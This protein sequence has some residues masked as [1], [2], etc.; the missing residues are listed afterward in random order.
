MHFVEKLQGMRF[1]IDV[2]CTKKYGL[3]KQMPM[4]TQIYTYKILSQTSEGEKSQ[5]KSTYSELE[6]LAPR[7]IFFLNPI[8][9]VKFLNDLYLQE[10][11]QRAPLMTLYKDFTD[12][13]VR[14]TS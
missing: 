3:I 9:L 6:N 2:Q 5:T 1:S 7:Y 11:T 14:F 10:T 4:P 8:I 13:V 12:E